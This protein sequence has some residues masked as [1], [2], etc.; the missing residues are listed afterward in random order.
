M[1]LDATQGE[2]EI[3]LS[4]DQKVVCTGR[5]TGEDGRIHVK[6]KLVND[7]YDYYDPEEWFNSLI[8]YV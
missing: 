3:L 6:Y 1:I 4:P 7:D 2:S 8:S 5:Y